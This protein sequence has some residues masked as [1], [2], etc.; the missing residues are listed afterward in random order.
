MNTRVFLRV[1]G[2]VFG[3]L[4]CYVLPKDYRPAARAFVRGIVN[5]KLDREIPVPE[6]ILRT[7][8]LAVLSAIDPYSRPSY[9]EAV[10]ILDKHQKAVLVQSY[11]YPQYRGDSYLVGYREH[12]HYYVMG[13]FTAYPQGDGCWLVQDR[14]DWHYKTLWS[15]PDQIARFIPSWILSVFC[16][17]N[18]KVWFL[19]EVGTLD[20]LTVPYWHRS[21]VKLSDY[22]TQDGLTDLRVFSEDDDWPI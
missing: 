1:L 14:Y 20:Q 13:A 9:E 19:K 4:I 17:R 3:W 15:V 12:P 5:S 2:Y 18:G 6:E 16:E 7:I 22:L 21:I 11:N 8:T 10:E